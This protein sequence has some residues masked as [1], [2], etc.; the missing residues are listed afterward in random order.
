MRKLITLTVLTTLIAC[1]TEPEF[2][3]VKE[4]P[5]KDLYLDSCMAYADSLEQDLYD[6][7]KKQAEE[8]LKE[9]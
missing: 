4:Q 9:L 6:F 8:A 3:E 1:N 5:V 2:K 7:K